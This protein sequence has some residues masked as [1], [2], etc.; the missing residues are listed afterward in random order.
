MP[1]HTLCA[2]NADS[3]TWC[4]HSSALL[5]KGATAEAIFPIILLEEDCL[6]TRTKPIVPF[7]V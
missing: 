1:A 2:L 7:A 5:H 4:G 6:E 3:G